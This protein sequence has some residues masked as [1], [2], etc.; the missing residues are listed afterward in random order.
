MIDSEIYRLATGAPD[1]RLDRLE[2]DIWHRVA[3]RERV[4]RVFSRL[5]ALQTAL[6]AVAFGASAIAGYHWE[7]PAYTP[8]LSVFST[9]SPLSAS[10]LLAG[11]KP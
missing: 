10:V 11:D 4:R 9:R 3:V 5:L 6:V 2:E 8:E 7:R 1:H